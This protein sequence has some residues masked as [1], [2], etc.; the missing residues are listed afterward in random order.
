[1]NVESSF[2]FVEKENVKNSPNVKITGNNCEETPIQK[3]KKTKK[4]V[5]R[6]MQLTNLPHSRIQS[7]V[8]LVE[9]N[10]DNNRLSALPNSLKSLSLL[11]SFSAKCNLFQIFPEVICSLHNL[12]EV[13]LSFNSITQL[14]MDIKSLRNLQILNISNNQLISLVEEVSRLSELRE[15]Y[16]QSNLLKNLPSDLSGM[17]SVSQIS[18]QDN[19]INKVPK[20]WPA[21][22]KTIDLSDNNLNSLHATDLFRNTSLEYLDLSSNQIDYIASFHSCMPLKKLSLS[23][24]RLKDVSF[25]L[26]LQNLE[27]LNMAR[28]ELT[29]L[30]PEICLLSHSLVHLVLNNNHI[31]SLPTSIG[32]LESLSFL[33]LSF[34]QIQTLPKQVCLLTSLRELNLRH[35]QISSIPLKLSKL[36]FLK[37][38]DIQNN[39]S[40][41]ETSPIH[42]PAP[43][44]NII[45]Q[46][47]NHISPRR[48]N[49]METS[50]QTTPISSRERFVVPVSNE[51]L[52]QSFV[53]QNFTQQGLHSGEEE[54]ELLIDNTKL[55]L[56]ASV[57]LFA[58]T[59]FLFWRRK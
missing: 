36:P 50:F 21:C 31:S 43:P 1:M 47:T 46:L 45:T 8:M 28:N 35:N 20:K 40:L 23:D 49:R 11:Q 53:Q 44:A 24:N 26:E 17:K 51:S 59:L 22:I 58:G 54:A 39:Y 52:Q 29:C 42:P 34:N 57:L 4:L 48:S 12:R 27:F 25:A 6:G 30:P 15:L 33:D 16:L 14:S 56:A 2:S 7:L 3:A 41:V 5:L 10:L 13:D 19:K 9:L 32:S 55:I 37:K 38:I 18:L